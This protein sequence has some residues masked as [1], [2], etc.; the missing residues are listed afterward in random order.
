MPSIDPSGGRIREMGRGVIE[1]FAAHHAVLIGIDAY[2]P[3]LRPLRTAVADVEAL[4]EALQ[5]DHGFDVEVRRD[6]DRAGLLR[7][8]EEELPARVGPDDRLLFYFAGH[9]V[10]QDSESGPRGYLVP[11]D[12]RAGATETMLVMTRVAAALQSL[13]CRHALVVL[14]CC[15]AGRFFW[16][17]PTRF[18]PL[19]PRLYRIRYQRYI[20]GAAWQAITSASHD[21]EALDEAALFGQ[22]G[23]TAEGHSP[24]AAALLSGLEGAADLAP[25]GGEPDGVITTAE[26]YLH[27]RAAVQEGAE[28]RGLRQTPRYFPLRKHDRGEFLFQVPNRRPNL[29]EDPELAPSANPWRGLR[30]YTEGDAALFFGRRDASQALVTRLEGG[31]E[32][33]TVV[34]GPSGSGKSSLVSAGVLPRLRAHDPAR[35]TIHG[36]F[37][38]GPHPAARLDEALSGVASELRRLL[39]VDQAE[40]VFT[41]CRDPEERAAFFEALQGLLRE[42]W[43]VLL[44]VRSDFH[45]QLANTALAPRL[46]AAVVPV[47]PLT[48]ADLREV[49]ERPAQERALFFEPPDLVDR[50]IQDLETMPGALPLLSFTLSELY[51]L[52]VRRSPTAR[53]L[54]RE[55][56]E[57]LGGVFGALH[58]RADALAG[59]EDS[60][61]ARAMR[62]LVLRMISTEGG[63]LARRRVARRELLPGGDGDGPVEALLE[64]MTAARLLVR[65]GGR[66]GEEDG[67]WFEPAHDALVLTWARVHRWLDQGGEH[68][69]IQRALWQ[70]A[71]HWLETGRPAG[72]LWTADPRL[73]LVVRRAREGELQLNA[74]ERAFVRAS[75]RRRAASRWLAGLVTLLVVA[76]L[77]VSLLDARQQ[78]EHAVAL[79]ETAEVAKVR[80][81]DAAEALGIAMAD[82]EQ[83]REAKEQ[84]REEAVRQRGEAERLRGVADEQRKEAEGLRVDADAQRGVAERLSEDLQV[85]VGQLEEALDE[86]EERQATELRITSAARHKEQRAARERAVDRAVAQA[87]W[88]AQLPDG[89]AGALAASL[90]ALAAAEGDED[91]R[92]EALVS[93]RRRL[94]AGGGR[95]MATSLGGVRAVSWGGG[96]L[97]ALGLGGDVEIW[98]PGASQAEERLVAAEG[99]APAAVALASDRLALGG[100]RGGL[101]TRALTGRGSGAEGAA[102]WALRLPAAVRELAFAGASRL[103]AMDT[104]GTLRLVDDAGAPVFTRGGVSTAAFSPDGAHIAV[105]GPG[106]LLLVSTADGAVIAESPAFTGAEEAGSVVVLAGGTGPP[107]VYAGTSSGRVVRW[108]PGSAPGVVAEHD[109]RAVTALAASRDGELVASAGRDGRV[110]LLRGPTGERLGSFDPTPPDRARARRG[111]PQ[112]LTDLAFVPGEG[113]L[114]V[115]NERGEVFLVEFAPDLAVEA[116]RRWLVQGE[117][118]DAGWVAFSAAGDYLAVRDGEGGVALHPMAEAPAIRAACARLDA[119]RRA[120]PPDA[121]L[122]AAPEGLCP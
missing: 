3:P 64:E 86:V 74:L 114:V 104:A 1:G 113:T 105:V 22:R 108:Q 10:A 9:G 46:P 112:P 110:V 97:A 47:P 57:A 41:I 62:P 73:L 48:G 58:S 118:P 66:E 107:I 111:G 84:E 67:V 37:A 90:D 34:V 69:P 102:P 101:Q 77:S 28:E 98:R 27:L 70:T 93:L 56:Y 100:R 121:V 60:E 52:S 83:E 54:R 16:A 18:E 11:R 7:L 13:P 2:E 88:L 35:W 94:A 38:P 15:F 81:E 49:I 23:V 44:S 99:F 12:G 39:V 76:S 80:A 45:P 40:E 53:E 25:P 43:T 24:F 55:D 59:D 96:R 6:P 17:A 85:S 29:P 78:R 122:P 63:R 117:G 50:L 75:A 51:D 120:A 4:G 61:R 8:L 116:R 79:A 115:A 91:L 72:S 36:P 109:D 71:L 42:G 20:E 19:P 21:E 89:E 14:D 103:L 82:K 68:L 26:L 87:G 65:S 33:L 32:P 95:S 31:V 106:W 5:R 30:A 119:H 92:E